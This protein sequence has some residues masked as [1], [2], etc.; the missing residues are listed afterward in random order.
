MDELLH[1]Q[2]IRYEWLADL[3]GFEMK[4]RM[5]GVLPE[6]DRITPMLEGIGR[7][8]IV[9]VVVDDIPETVSFYVDEMTSCKG[10]RYIGK[11]D[12]PVDDTVMLSFGPELNG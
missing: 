9:A 11:K 7:G 5:M 1:C 4:G 6:D 2:S 3:K 10:V 12:G 8:N